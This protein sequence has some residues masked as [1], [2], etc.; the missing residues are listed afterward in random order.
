M[1]I[2]L[3]SVLC[4]LC[5]LQACA[6]LPGAQ[7]WERG[8][9]AKPAMSLDTDSLDARFVNHIYDSKESSSGGL[10]VG[11]GGCGCN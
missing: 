1:S 5:L 4:A 8:N 10:G 11:G 3:V 9:L 7:P 6:A 2:K